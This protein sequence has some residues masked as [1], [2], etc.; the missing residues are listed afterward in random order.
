MENVRRFRENVVHE[1]PENNFVDFPI[2]RRML[3]GTCLRLGTLLSSRF[4]MNCLVPFAKARAPPGG[5]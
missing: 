5:S 2:Q 3:R 1:W 4:S